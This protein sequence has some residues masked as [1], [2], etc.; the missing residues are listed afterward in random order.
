M[1]LPL[2]IER[3]ARCIGA[4]FFGKLLENRVARFARGVCFGGDGIAIAD[5]RAQRKERRAWGKRC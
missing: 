2:R 5:D 4:C 3:A 1:F